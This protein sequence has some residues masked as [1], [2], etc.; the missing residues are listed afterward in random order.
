VPAA[1][2]GPASGLLIEHD[3]NDLRAL[4]LIERKWRLFQLMARPS[5]EPSGTTSIGRV[6]GRCRDRRNFPH[7]A[8]RAPNSGKTVQCADRQP[9]EESPIAR[10]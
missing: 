3:G 9:P 2:G 6:T 4:P 1:E 8:R 5:G 7:R 10:A